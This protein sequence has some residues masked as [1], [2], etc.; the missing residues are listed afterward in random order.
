MEEGLTFPKQEIRSRGVGLRALVAAVIAA[1]ALGGVIAFMLLRDGGE[2]TGELFRL[3]NDVPVATAPLSAGGAAT[4]A[5]VATASE[6]A[7]IVAQEAREAVER[8]EQVEEQAGGIDQRVAAM[9]Q[10][11][12]RL[13]LQS[14]A[15]AGNAARAEGMLVAFA[16]RRA[17]ERGQALG[18]LEDQL[19]L[20]FGDARPNAVQTVIAAS[21]DPV[22]LSQLLVRL[23][24]IANELT[25]VPESAGLWSRLGHEFSQLFAIRTANT[26]SPVAERR[27][28]RARAGLETGQLERAIAE[29]RAMPNAAAAEGWLVDAE[30]YAAAQRALEVLETAAVLEPRELRDASGE[31]VSQP[32]PAR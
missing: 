11:L 6:P 23:D 13:D 19:R 21:Q 5:P 12:T 10:R 16:S 26:P 27:L 31:R 4:T 18:F 24:G 1:F 17:I 22:T 28:E 29:V 30:R 32:S 8:V 20:R 9:E 25:D 7:A 3:R 2:G 14:Q 15:A